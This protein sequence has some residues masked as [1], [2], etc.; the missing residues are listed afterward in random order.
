MGADD[1]LS[2][3]LTAVLSQLADNEPKE[4]GDLFVQVMIAAEQRARADSLWRI[5]SALVE[6]LKAMIV[7]STM[8]PHRR[9]GRD[10]ICRGERLQILPALWG[11]GHRHKN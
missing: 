3:R 5:G 10:T 6:R 2:D 1:A 11:V 4:L 8:L 7:A 9:R